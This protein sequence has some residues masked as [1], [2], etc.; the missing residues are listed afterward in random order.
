MIKKTKTIKLKDPILIACWPGMGEVAIKSG[1][2]LRDTLGFKEF[3]EIQNSGLF[4][5]AGIMVENGI[6]SMPDFKEGIFYHWRGKKKDIV[7][8]LAEIQPALDKGYVFSKKIIEFARS[9]KI[10]TVITFAAMPSPIEHTQPTV[11]WVAATEKNI[12]QE[13]TRYGAKAVKEGQISGLNGLLIG[14]AREK[15]MKGFCLLGEIPL[16]T[17]QIENPKASK[18]VLEIVSKY[19]GIDLELSSFDQKAQYIDQEIN[20]LIGYLKGE[21]PTATPLS[22]DDI[23]KIKNELAR[24]TRLPASIEEKIEDLFKKSHQEAR[25]STEL[26]KLLDDWGV[27]KKYE[28][29]FLDLFRK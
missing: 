4:E 13:C 5:P 6:I 17:I 25:Y 20:K 1:I 23:T 8:F 29:R 19:L 2:F 3:A 28:D 22:E 24:L 18:A 11:T 26:K 27:Y 12:L 14:V 21:N 16:Y 9:L 10:K 7:L 15:R